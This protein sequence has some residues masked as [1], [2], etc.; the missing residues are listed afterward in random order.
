MHPRRPRPHDPL[1]ESLT[2]AYPPPSVASDDA[3]LSRIERL[4]T[5]AD[6][7]SQRLEDR[8]DLTAKFLTQRIED[9]DD[10]INK[11]MQALDRKVDA[12]FT[13]LDK[14]IRDT[15]NGRIKVI[16]ERYSW[17]RLLALAFVLAAITMA[18]G[19]FL[20]DRWGRPLFSPLMAP[21]KSQGGG[22]S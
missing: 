12:G 17:V 2:T 10:K 6:A 5:D 1:A 13:A 8:V 18:A 16:E 15:I 11:G 7:R 3:R 4:A 20:A 19:A 9:F 14:G 22:P 21:P